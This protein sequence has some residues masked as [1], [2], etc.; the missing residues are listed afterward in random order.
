MS[1]AIYYP[2]AWISSAAMVILSAMLVISLQ[3][4]SNGNSIYVEAD[5]VKLL[6]DAGISGKQAQARLGSFGRDIRDV[7]A[8]IISHDHRDHIA[9][10]GVYQRKFSLPM[11][12]TE[13]TLTAA[14]RKIGLG[15]LDEIHHFDSGQT[16][17]FG[18]VMVETIPTPHDGADGNG[19]IV[20]AEGRRLG[21]LT[22]LGHVFP[23]LAAAVASLDAVFIESNYDPEM[24][25]SGNYPA[26]LK[27]RI[28]GQGGHIS[29]IESAELLAE[30]GHSL[31]W[32]CLAH[33]SQDNNSPQLALQTHR[34]VL[35]A[36]SIPM[37]PIHVA[38]RYE[39][40]EVFEVKLSGEKN[41]VN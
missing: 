36:S 7:D 1:K 34:Q 18:D 21:I 3:S 30:H 2:L 5:G 31:Q 16:L 6:F 19:F 28:Q 13:E 32:A 40:S 10:A 15:K 26:F 39:A 29:N 23:G 20:A 9:S 38:T 33:L 24:L 27:A 22:D 41:A 11:Y 4:G 25:A 12:L 17:R 14:D 8:M 37:I 35:G